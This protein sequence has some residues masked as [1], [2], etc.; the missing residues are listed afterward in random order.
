MCTHLYVL[1]IYKTWKMDSA[2]S[3]CKGNN[4][5]ICYNNVMISYF[6]LQSQIIALIIPFDSPFAMSVSLSRSAFPCSWKQFDN[7]SSSRNATRCHLQW[8]G[9]DNCSISH[10]FSKVMLTKNETNL[11]HWYDSM[12]AGAGWARRSTLFSYVQPSGD[13]KYSQLLV[14]QLPMSS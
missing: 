4:T 13:V 10:S 6:L 1:Y 3:M 2:V 7:C 5:S 11:W 12:T 8:K 14:Y 9:S